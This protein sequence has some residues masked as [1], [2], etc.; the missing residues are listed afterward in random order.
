MAAPQI[1]GLAGDI[2][3][4]REEMR[5]TLESVRSDATAASSE[6]GDAVTMVRADIKDIRDATAELRGEV[7]QGSNGG[8]SLSSPPSPNGGD[9]PPPADAAESRAQHFSD[10][11]PSLRKQNF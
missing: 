9:A 6:F 4:I 5:K 8:P 11:H 2:R 1:R 3:A 7:A 10:I